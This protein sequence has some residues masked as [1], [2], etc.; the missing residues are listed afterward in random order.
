MATKAMKLELEMS[1]DDPE[2]RKATALESL[3]EAEL[4]ARLKELLATLDKA[5]SYPES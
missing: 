3:S 2:S 5:G 4:D 1:G